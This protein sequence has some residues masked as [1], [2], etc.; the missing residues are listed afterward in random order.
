MRYPEFAEQ[1]LQMMHRDLKMR[2][3]LI[4]EGKLSEGYHEDMRSIHTQN[5]EILE[6]IIGQIGYPND[7]KVGKEASEAAWIVIQHAIEKPAF[8]KKCKELLRNEVDRKRADP[9]HLAC[10]SDR[11]T[12]L[13]GQ[14]QEYGT[15]FDWN[16]EGVMAPEHMDDIEKVN[17]RRR[18]LGWNNVEEQ[19][20]MIRKKAESENQKP[21]ACYTQ[22]LQEI[23]KWKKKTGW[24]Q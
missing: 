14:P 10:L 3:K 15:Q 6:E 21:P 24:I 23:S 17:R 2:E 7:A 4:S 9:K 19:T 1:I 22:R 11:I 12:V 8:M 13:S 20:A 18:E 5:I 16:E